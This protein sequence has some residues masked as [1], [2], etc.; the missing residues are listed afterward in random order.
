MMLKLVHTR[1]GVGLGGNVTV[2]VSAV[3]SSPAGWR[4]QVGLVHYHGKYVS[5]PSHM[6]AY[7][8]EHHMSLIPSPENSGLG[9]K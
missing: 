8:Y 7:T 5:I 9:M 2:R 4:E 1:P 6:S 3:K